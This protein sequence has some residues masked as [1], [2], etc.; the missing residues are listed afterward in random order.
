MCPID[1]PVDRVEAPIT[2]D[3]TENVLAY[4]QGLLSATPGPP[5]PDAWLRGL[6][7]AFAARAAGAAALVDGLAPVKWRV[8]AEPGDAL[9]GPWPWEVSPEFAGPATAAGDTRERAAADATLLGAAVE[10]ANGVGWL[11]WLEDR[12]RRRWAGGERAAL[13][14]AAGWLA[15]LC[16]PC[17]EEVV[18][19]VRRQRRLEEAAAVAGRLAHDFGNVL[20]GVLGFGELS[21]AQLAP[22][23]PAH[24]Q[25]GELF[26]AARAGARMVERLM[27]FSRRRSGA[28]RPCPVRDV[29]AREA[30][31][32]AKDWPR[33]VALET[34]LAEG[35]PPA[36]LEAEALS[37]VLGPILENAREAVGPAGQVVVTA[38]ARQLTDADCLAYVGGPAPGW[39]VEVV[40]ADTGAGIP[41]A[42]GPRLFREPFVTTKPGRRGLGLA[43]AY[44]VLRANRGGLCLGPGPAGGTAVR[45]VLPTASAPAA[46]RPPTPAGSREKVLVVDDD[47]LA[48]DMVCAVLRRAGYRVEAASGGD[49]ALG[50]YRA[51]AA[52]PFRMVLSDVVMPAMSG[53]D[54]ARHLQGLDPNVKVLFITGQV[55]Q[56]APA[57]EPPPRKVNL[58][59][60]PFRPD[61]LLQAVRATLDCGEPV[62]AG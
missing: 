26:Q 29:L 24:R 8:S 49:Q 5:D 10:A 25:V 2:P 30:A 45:V 53:L 47:P 55:A 3:R 60:K 54:L 19:A 57:G 34:D 58:L 1:L 9:P 56:F 62:L 23:T 44:G 18:E 13:L 39:H 27:L 51:A 35:L 17:L 31:R 21:L 22:G 20:T 7:R 38:R 4:V 46:E 32:A 14:L 37:Q 41:P 15:R 6:A 11:V 42:L 61:G 52:D 33:A 59:P 50:A 43:A 48:L 16:R 36:A 40:V 28:G 12:T